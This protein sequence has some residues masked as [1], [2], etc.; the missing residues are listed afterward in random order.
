MRTALAKSL[1]AVTSAAA[2]VSLFPVQA[3]AN[4]EINFTY[5]R[6]VVGLSGIMTVTGDMNQNV[7]RAQFARMLV[8][9]SSYRSILTDTSNVSVFADVKSGDE[10]ASAIR[11]CAEH[12]WM[13]GF[14]GGN[15]RPDQYVT[16]NEAAKGLLY[17]LGYEASDFDGDQYN[18]R[19]AQYAHLDLNENVGY[20]DPAT[21]ITREDCV[22]LFYNL[23][24][25]QKKNGGNY[26]EVL[27]ASLSSDGEVNALEMAD[28]TVVGPKL[29]E[30]TTELWSAIPFDVDD[31]N[32]F[33]NGVE[34]SKDALRAA[35]GNYLVLYY[36]SPTRTVWAYSADED[37]DADRRVVKGEI[38]HIYYQS[39]STITPSSVELDDGSSYALS[40]S[41][42]Q[43]AF[44]IYGDLKVG[45]QVALIYTV[46]RPDSDGESTYTVVDF[47]EP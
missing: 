26:A 36:S 20:S 35:A 7:T 33:L 43:F 8:R 2:A 16:L 5:R 3:F 45:D 31:A 27:D 17:L 42:M 30:D 24:K 22:N 10:Y 23:L 28:N 38:T 37:S 41:E 14:L 19:M 4:T 1:L 12:G 11:I 47:C 21:L 25:A 9:A 32:V 34:S 40:S 6:K 15:F 18:R 13:T 29:V 39:T 44:S 46:S